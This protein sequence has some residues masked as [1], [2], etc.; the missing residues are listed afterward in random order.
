MRNASDRLRDLDTWSPVGD[1]EEVTEFSGPRTL[2]EEEGHSEEAMSTCSFNL[3]FSLR[4]SCVCDGNGVTLTPA[5]ALAFVSSLA[6]WTPS[7]EL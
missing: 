1:S 6:R 2:L 5:P 4:T 3:L 7:L